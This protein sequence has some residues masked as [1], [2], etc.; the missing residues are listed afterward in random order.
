MQVLEAFQKDAPMA[1]LLLN[2]RV[3]APGKSPRAAS[4]MFIMEPCLSP[5]VELH[6]AACASQAGQRRP[7]YVR[8]LYAQVRACEGVMRICRAQ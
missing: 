5:A 6:L 2:M 3:V 7:V 1:A 8:R 4:H